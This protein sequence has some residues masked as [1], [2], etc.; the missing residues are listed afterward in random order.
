MQSILSPPFTHPLH[1]GVG[2]AIVGLSDISSAA[3][4]GGETHKPVQAVSTQ[5]PRPLV[6]V[7]GPSDF[8]LKYFG[9]VVSA[10]IFKQPIIQN[11]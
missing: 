8:R 10:L 2:E 5:G 11:L 9:E 7:L 1:E 3:G 6:Q 4:H